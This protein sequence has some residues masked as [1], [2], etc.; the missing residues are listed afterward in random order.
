MSA[1]VKEAELDAQNQETRVNELKE[2][3]EAEIQLKK[4]TDSKRKKH[5]DENTKIIEILKQ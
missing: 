2:K 5:T 3:L 1:K 4:E